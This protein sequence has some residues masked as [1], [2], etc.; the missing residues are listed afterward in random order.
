MVA[1]EKQCASRST[2]TPNKT[3]SANLYRRIKRRGGGGG[4]GGGAHLAHC[5]RHLVPSRKKAAYKLPRTESSL[6]GP[7]GV[8]GPLLRQDSSCSNRQHHSGVL[9]K[10][11]RRHEVGPPPPVCPLVEN[12]D[13]VYHKTGY[14]QSPTHPRLAECGSRQAIKARPDHPDR[15]VSPSGGFFNQYAASGTGLR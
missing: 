14:P 8:P 11:G 7:E 4:G 10:Q 13:L 2:I 6:F 5:K 1:G 12:P 9:H 15:V 3:C